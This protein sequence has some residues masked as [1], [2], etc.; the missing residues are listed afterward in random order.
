MS[1]KAIAVKSKVVAELQEKIERSNVLLIADYLKFS[2][3]DITLLRKALRKEESEL[4]VVKNSLLERALAGAG[5][6]TLKEFLKGST[7]L[8]LGYKDAVTPIKVFAKF[9]KET[10]KGDIRAGIVEKGVFNKAQL[11]EMAKLPSKEIL[12]GK[13]VGGFKAPLFGIVNVLQGPIRKL[14]YALNE[15]KEKKGG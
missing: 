9:I 5:F 12:I 7:V 10:E 8:L 4:T 11:N 15:I 13:V 1:E 2:V 14:V 6:D 3:K